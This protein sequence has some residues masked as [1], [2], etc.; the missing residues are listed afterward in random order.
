MAIGKAFSL[1]FKERRYWFIAIAIA[2]AVAAVYYGLI[3][4][5]ARIPGQLM[6]ASIEYI[7]T[8][9]TLLGFISVLFGLNVSLLMYKYR[10][11]KQLGLKETGASALGVFAGS[12]GAGCPVCGA[13]VLSLLGVSAGLSVFPLKGLEVQVLGVGLLLIAT[14]LNARSIVRNCCI[15]KG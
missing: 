8:A 15:V 14:F 11:L 7:V 13:L 10:Q 4:A 9:F 1:V 12:M 5:V 3:K 6:M 2:L